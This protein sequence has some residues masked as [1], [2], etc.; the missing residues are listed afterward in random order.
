M[1]DPRCA[2]IAERLATPL[3]VAVSGRAGVGRS[4]VAKALARAGSLAVTTGSDADLHVYVIAEVVKPEDRVAIGAVTRP[5]LTVLTKADLIAT[6]EAGRYPQGP[7][8]AARTRCRQLSDRTGLSIE[9]LVGILAVATL[10]DE[11]WT[12]LRALADG[13][14]TEVQE[15]LVQELDLFG[16][17]QATAAIR[18]GATRTEVIALLRRLSCID[19]VVHAIEVLGAQVRYQRVLDAVADLET[20]AVTDPRVGEFLCS[21][22]TVVAR[23]MA[24]VDI[25]EAR[26]IPVY[27]GDT[28]DAHLRRA[29]QW[30]QDKS[31]AG[32]DIVRGSLR[33]WAEV[34]G[35]V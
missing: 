2:A 13:R 18:L 35:T 15:R 11:L 27:R 28:A 33:L 31:L 4:T 8:S 14:V 25:V 17:A 32:S 6:T 23:M 20:L 12:G 26:G 10:D 24:A 21:D 29:M 7:T 16:I 30:R 9:P 19:D 1:R 34:G 3:R 5:V 22:D